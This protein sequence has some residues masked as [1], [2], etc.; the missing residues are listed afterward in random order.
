MAPAGLW[1]RITRLG[2]GVH[3]ISRSEVLA[4]RVIEKTDINFRISTKVC[5]CLEVYTSIT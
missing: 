1:C 2:G 3:C 5:S 4:E